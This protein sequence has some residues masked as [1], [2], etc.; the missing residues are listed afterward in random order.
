MGTR[1]FVPPD[2]CSS[3]CHW[4]RGSPTRFLSRVTPGCCLLFNSDSNLSHVEGGC[5]PL[6]VCRQGFCGFFDWTASGLVAIQPCGSEWRRWRSVEIIIF[7]FAMEACIFF[8]TV[9][10]LPCLVENIL[11]SSE[12]IYFYL[13]ACCRYLH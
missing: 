4:H 11:L 7:H 5:W 6:T 1:R 2:L 12:Q 10:T 3:P 9:G 8:S 13:T